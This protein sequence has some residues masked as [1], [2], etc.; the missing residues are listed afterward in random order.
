MEVKMNGWVERKAKGQGNKRGDSKKSHKRLVPFSK[1]E[2]DFP[3]YR[4]LGMLVSKYMIDYSAN[5]NYLADIAD[6]IKH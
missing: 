3:I 1:V 2:I 6:S 5:I 4:T